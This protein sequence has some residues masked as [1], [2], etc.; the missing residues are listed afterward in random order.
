[1]PLRQCLGDYHGREHG[2][3]EVPQKQWAGE[4]HSGRAA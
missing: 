2:W 4:G 1:M 3:Q